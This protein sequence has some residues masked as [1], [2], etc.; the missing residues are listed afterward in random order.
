MNFLK[1][2]I[3]TLLMPAALVSCQKEK[4]ITPPAATEKSVPVSEKKSIEGVWAGQ[5][6]MSNKNNP[7]FFSFV[8]KGEGKLDVIDASQQVMGSG[9]W[10]LNGNSFKAAYTVASSGAAYSYSVAAD[11]YSGSPDKF[12]GTWGYN[13]NDT[14]GGFW[15]MKKI[16]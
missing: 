9:A 2:S 6:V 10:T 16:N 15:D 5:S 14:G 12:N 3:V 1:L 4:D 13:S 7:V 11:Y 8:I